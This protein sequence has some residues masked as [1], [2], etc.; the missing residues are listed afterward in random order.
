MKYKKDWFLYKC[1]YLRLPLT[2]GRRRRSPV[3]QS[4]F[5]FGLLWRRGCGWCFLHQKNDFWVLV[6]NNFNYQAVI[7][8]LYNNLWG[9]KW[10]ALFILVNRFGCVGLALRKGKC[11]LNINIIFISP[12]TIIRVSKLNLRC[13]L[14]LRR[15]DLHSLLCHCGLQMLAGSVRPPIQMFCQL[16]HPV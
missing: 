1:L 5:L 14:Q 8:K 4:T 6:Q 3:I 11:L 15:W 13:V 2:L 10:H 16:I 12:F 9:R 7:K